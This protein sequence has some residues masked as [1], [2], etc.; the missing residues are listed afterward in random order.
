MRARF[1]F[2]IVGLSFGATACGGGGGGGAP[3]PSGKPTFSI[4]GLPAG[5]LS[6]NATYTISAVET[7]GGTAVTPGPLTVSLDNASVGKVSGTTLLAG[8]A[9]ASGN[10]TVADASRGLSATVV[11]SVA[12]THPATAGDTVDL[13]GSLTQT[14]TRPH[15]APSAVPPPFVSQATITI[16]TTTS[17]GATFAGLAGLTDFK[18]IEN[19]T[20]LSP[21]ITTTTTTDS[22]QRVV[23][24]GTAFDIVTPGDSASDSNGNTFTTTYGAGNGLLLDVLPETNGGSFSNDAALVAT[25]SDAGGASANRTVNPDGSYAETDA[26]ADRTT[27]SIAV[28]ADLS[29]TLNNLRGQTTTSVA[30]GA[31]KPSSTGTGKIVDYTL[32]I[33]SPPSPHV[34]AIFDWYPT[35]ALASDTVTTTTGQNIPSTCAVPTSVGTSATLLAENFTRLDPVLGTYEVRS[36][37]TYL[38][39]LVGVVCVTISDTLDDHYD[40]SGQVGAFVGIDPTGAPIQTTVTA[41]TI[42]LKTASVAGAPT[43][44]QTH[45]SGFARSDAIQTLPASS[46]AQHAFSI[47]KTAFDRLMQRA[48]AKRRTRL[49]DGLA[50]ASFVKEVI[51]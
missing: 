2:S 50:R 19:E 41:E 46:S 15:P 9:N 39:P 27:Q 4:A 21:A 44:L 31:P 13:A 48:Y 7:I 36:T 32:T 35:T 12:T 42:G 40:Y 8:L 30:V 17:I 18:S 49:R 47:A 45:A 16:A 25:E 29:G 11:V 5:P 37:A 33:G 22:Y 38:S 10:V 1:L 43:G 6:P 23:P 3:T 20:T 51:R 26:F 28:N 14:I 34:L 24:N